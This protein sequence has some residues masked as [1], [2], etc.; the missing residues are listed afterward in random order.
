MAALRFQTWK[1]S[2]FSSSLRLTNGVYVFQ[3]LP[4]SLENP[5][6][7]SVIIFLVNHVAVDDFRAEVWVDS[8]PRGILVRAS[9]AI[10]WNDL[11]EMT[12]LEFTQV[13]QTSWHNYIYWALKT[14]DN[15]GVP[16][17]LRI[18]IKVHDLQWTSIKHNWN[19]MSQLLNSWRNRNL[20]EVVWPRN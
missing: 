15:Q 4:E 12:R 14:Q 1:T 9:S 5:W 17:V 3:R 19:V 13:N 7:K 11:E 6:S 20:W 2:S 10:E 18:K 16:C 8:P